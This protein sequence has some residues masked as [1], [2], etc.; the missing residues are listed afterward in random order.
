VPAGVV[1]RSSRTLYHGHDHAV[2]VEVVLKGGGSW[3]SFIGC[4]PMQKRKAPEREPF[5]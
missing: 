1:N 3:G 5:S 2:R 4:C